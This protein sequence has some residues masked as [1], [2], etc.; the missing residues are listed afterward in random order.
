M[1]V[2]E[3]SHVKA[4]E[5]EDQGA[6]CCRRGS[7]SQGDAQ[8]LEAQ[9]AEQQ[10]EQRE[11][12]QRPGP[13]PQVIE[14]VRWP[15]QSAGV[16]CV[17]R[18][19]QVVVRVPQGRLPGPQA[20]GEKLQP[21]LHDDPLVQQHRVGRPM[22]GRLDFAPGVER[23]QGVRL[24]EHP[25]SE[26]GLSQQSDPGQGQQPG[27]AAQAALGALRQGGLPVGGGARGGARIRVGD[28]HS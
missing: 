2:S 15:Q 8:T 7:E 18:L 26:Q 22:I 16:G 13:R 28:V 20:L 5:T 17:D 19:T 24:T 12:H 9:A 1:R 10:F 27:P 23:Q 6:R 4:A 25:G 3:P 14:Q 21:G 11:K